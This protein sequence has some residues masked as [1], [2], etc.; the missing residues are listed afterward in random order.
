MSNMSALLMASLLGP[1]LIAAVAAAT[2]RRNPRL[3]GRLGAAVAGFGFL[4]A[5]VLAVEAAR[6]HAVS[7]TVTGAGGHAVLAAAAD[8]LAVVLLLLVFGVST[9]VQTFA[10][11]Y[12]AEDPRSG[13]FT[14]G[15][16]LL[17]TASALLMTAQTLV[18]LAAGWSLAGLALCLLL[19][20]YWDLPAARDGVRRTATAFLIGDLA[21]WTAVVLVATRGGSLE[22]AALG[23]EPLGG[24]VAAIAA[25]LVVL[26]A[27]SRSAQ[28]PFHRW[29]PATLAAPT[30]VSALLHA[31]VVNA[32]GI[33]LIKLAA[34]TA[35]SG[36]ARALTI[37]AGIATLAYGAVIM[38]VKPDIKGALAHSTMAQM[39]FMILTCGLGLWAAAV[40]HLVAHGF[41]KATLFLSSGSAIAYRR[42][43][44][45]L[46]P[47]PPTAA[48]RCAALIAALALPTA[49]LGL[50][51][52]VVPTGS[53]D[54]AAE[55][56]LLLFAW[57]TSAA[58]IWGWLK[59]RPGPA[60][61][62]AAAAFL[63]PAS[64]AYVW[65]ITTVSGFLAPALPAAVLPAGA[66]WLITGAALTL[67]AGLAALRA[68]P[69]ADRLQRALYARAL[70]AGHIAAP[71][72]PSSIRLTGA[73]S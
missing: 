50:A 37:G 46:P 15:A 1:V 56:A 22:L 51:V 7:V 52:A 18:V 67:L 27:L 62:L 66:T 26:A 30:P 3:V 5:A 33:L 23:G 17:T 34:L 36:P 12:L 72:S 9:I 73:R 6:G 20:T 19:A 48:Q 40:F 60:G 47:A 61:V 58:A 21:L 53:G 24:P 8:R 43:K 69:G 16:G 4:T 55:R 10:V 14:A 49:A 35:A 70:S 11:R 28:V 71:T 31:G 32:G 2:G 63:A 29:L 57:V 44:V 42:R 39:G 45:M 64:L 25:C 38:L 41:Y 54:H 13:W 65:L 68:A 59:R